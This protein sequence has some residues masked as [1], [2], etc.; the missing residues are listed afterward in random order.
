MKIILFMILHNG[1]GGAEKIAGEVRHSLQVSKA[2]FQ[3]FNGYAFVLRLHPPDGNGTSGAAVGV[4][5]IKDVPQPVAPVSVHQQG[6]PRGAPI[7]PPAML[8]PKVGLSA[9]GGVRLLGEN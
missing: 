1:F 6:N 2:V 4:R 5:H 7:H 3:R 9:G 8:V